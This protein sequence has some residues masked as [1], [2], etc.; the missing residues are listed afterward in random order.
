MWKTIFYGHL[1]VRVRYLLPAQ[2][3]PEAIVSLFCN[4]PEVSACTAWAVK[5]HQQVLSTPWQ[6]AA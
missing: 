6:H 1:S 2:L 3:P 4:S 5:D